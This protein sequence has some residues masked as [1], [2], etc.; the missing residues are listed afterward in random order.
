MAEAEG[1]AGQVRP[2]AAR[3]RL[4]FIPAVTDVGP[5]RARSDDSRPPQAATPSRSSPV[6]L[7][8][9][10]ESPLAD[11]ASR[12]R[13]HHDRPP[14]GAGRSGSPRPTIRCR[15]ACWPI[16]S[17]SIISA[18]AC[19][20]RPAIS[21][22]WASRRR[23]PNCSTIW[24][25]ELLDQRLVAQAA[26]P[27]DGHVG[28]LSAGVARA[29]SRCQRRQGPAQSLARP[30]DR[31]PA[32]GRADSRRGDC[33]HAANSIREWAAKAA[34]AARRPAARS[35]SRSS[36]TSR[37]PTLDVFDV[38]DGISTMP[39]RNL[40]TTPTQSLF[41][42]NGPWMML[43]AKAFARRAR[44]AVVGHARAASR[45]R[46]RPD[47]RPP[48]QRRRSCKPPPPSCKPIRADKPGRPRRFLPRAVELQRVSVRRLTWA[49][50]LSASVALTLSRRDML[51]Q[52]RHR[53]R[54]AGPR[55]A[56][57]VKDAR[58]CLPQ[59]PAP[60]PWP[61]PPSAPPAQGQVRH[62]P[63]HGRRP[64]PHRHVRS[65]A[66]AEEA[67]RPA[68]A[69]VVQAGHPGDGREEP[70]APGQP[71]EVG[72]AR[73]RR[74]VGQRLAAAHGDLCRRPV[75]RPLALVATAST[76]PAASAR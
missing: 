72:P 43:R 12:R 54:R 37:T 5:D 76:T 40:T 2:P 23:I 3:S 13:R 21:A 27:A 17:G 34:T 64:E 31:A 63:L 20:N 57:S 7:S 70:A 74:P 9:L 45:D 26:A 52:R 56:C 44:A 19:A 61:L 59:P 38:P 41:M 30:H 14:H 68:A 47:L 46:L 66:G 50:C 24:R 51:C 55:R 75:R 73:R 35:I 69:R 28:R 67:R 33:R 32:G 60:S 25:R 53:L 36:A 65:Q 42:I 6:P 29:G 58:R 71:A 10:D 18:A 22:A 15:R 1:R 11:R 62:L 4:P 48:A 8:V 39:V 16:A 49:T